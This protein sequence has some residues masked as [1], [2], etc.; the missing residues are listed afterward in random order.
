MMHSVT[1]FYFN[2]YISLKLLISTQVRGAVPLLQ[3]DHD[4]LSFG[5]LVSL[6]RNATAEKRLKH[7]Q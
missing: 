1:R 7:T 3:G 5:I 4:G 6:G 2:L